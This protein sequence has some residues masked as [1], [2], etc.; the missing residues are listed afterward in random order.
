MSAKSAAAKGPIASHKRLLDITQRRLEKFVSLFAKVI[1]RDRP[2][3][4]HDVRVASRRL[5]QVLRILF[6][7]PSG[8][9]SRKLV[10]RLRKVR[11][12]LG[13]CRNLD[14][15]NGLVQGRIDAARNS[16]LCD[17]WN[18][19]REDILQQRAAEFGRARDALSRYDIVAFVGRTEDL[20]HGNRVGKDPE[21]TLRESINLALQRWEAAMAAAKE[22]HEPEQLH[23]L[24]IASKRLRYRLEV[25]ADLDDSNARAQV[26]M[27]KAFQDELGDWHDRH[28]MLGFVAEFL[29]RPNFL[30]NHPAA[31][32]ALLL[33]ME[34]ERRRNNAAVDSILKHADKVRQAWT[35]T[36]P[37]L[38]PEWVSQS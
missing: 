31:G 15:I 29:G 18:R 35:E 22:N 34:R 26:E 11:R 27:L 33:D 3:T 2:G 12:A 8:A 10:G 4:I 9:K 30:V 1:V 36:K 24:R 23:A 32:R 16:A 7:K 25:L 21:K 28:V 38:S 13:H 6:P 14:V 17:A 19:V 20:I 5:Q 37:A